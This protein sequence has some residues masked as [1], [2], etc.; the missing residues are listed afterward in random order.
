ML[1]KRSA[2]VVVAL[3]L[4]VATGSCRERS[5]PISPPE[6]QM[7]KGGKPTGPA[8]S[9]EPD[10]QEFWVYTTDDEQ[11]VHIVMSGTYASLGFNPAYDYFFNGWQDVDDHYEVY[12]TG[13]PGGDIQYREV[14]GV[15]LGHTDIC[16]HGER[17]YTTDGPVYFK[18][19]PTTDVDGSGGDPI[20]LVPVAVIE[21]T[22]RTQSFR[23]FRP[24]G[25][26]VGGQV[27]RRT[28]SDVASIWHDGAFPE[29]RSFAISHGEEA[30]KRLFVGALSIDNVTCTATTATTGSGRNKQRVAIAKVDLGAELGISADPGVEYWVETH[31]LVFPEVDGHQGSEPIFVSPRKTFNDATGSSLTT[32]SSAS[33]QTDLAGQ[34]VYVELAVDYLWGFDSDYVYDPRQNA[35]PHTTAGFGYGTD[36]NAW[37]ASTNASTTLDDGKFP[38]AHSDAVRVV[39]Q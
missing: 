8:A 25:V 19:F 35:V 32:T 21:S 29:V 28:E 38:V 33:F 13:F 11:C 7:A 23:Q 24:R 20:A 26:V 2:L 16:Y 10:L 4:L 22:D 37:N 12:Q 1:G 18:D 36:G 3:G 34:A 5:N 14:D 27:E 9:T 15:A 30:T 17:Q 6:P 31:V 39:C